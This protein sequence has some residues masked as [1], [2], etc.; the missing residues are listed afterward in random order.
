[1]TA[2]E[3]FYLRLL[4]TAPDSRRAWLDEHIP[5]GAAPVPHWLPLIESAISDVRY[6]RRGWP[7]TRPRADAVLAGSLIEWALKRGYPIHLA[8]GHLI[9]LRDL[10]PPTGGLPANLQ[11]DHLVRLTLAGI[12]MTRSH[13][14]T[15]AAQLRALP[16]DED[17]AKTLEALQATDDYQDYHRLMDIQGMLADLAPLASSVTD[18][19]LAADLAEWLRITN[20]LEPFPTTEI[21]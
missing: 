8:I 20:R 11:T 7:T 3:D 12:T 14:L 4:Q 1:M 16:A 17:S 10:M 2:Y 6:E 15:R 19:V 18:P 9:E 13:A 21:T 5:A